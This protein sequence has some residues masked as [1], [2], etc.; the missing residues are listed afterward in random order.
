MN[1]K[2][3]QSKFPISIIQDLN[4]PIYCSYGCGQLAKFEFKNGNFG[5]ND[6]VNKCP[7]KRQNASKKETGR[8]HTEEHNRKIGESSSKWKNKTIRISRKSYK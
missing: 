7:S 6:H 8:K 5:C 3:K 2:R 4:N 1:K